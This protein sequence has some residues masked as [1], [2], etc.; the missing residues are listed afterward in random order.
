MA[1]WYHPRILLG[2]GKYKLPKSLSC[3]SS[4]RHS[5]RD[6][7]E[8]APSRRRSNLDPAKGIGPIKI[9]RGD[10]I[11]TCDPLHPMQVR[12]QAAPRPDRGTE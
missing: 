12:Y 6:M 10:K 7:P 9:G 3:V 1:D 5:D 4:K 8:E 11:R 2:S